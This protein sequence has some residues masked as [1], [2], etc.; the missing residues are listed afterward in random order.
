M[1]IIRSKVNQDFTIVLNS[2][3]DDKEFSSKYL[4]TFLRL[5]S[6][7]YGW[8]VSAD[9]LATLYPTEKRD[10]YRSALKHMC[11]LGYLIRIPQPRVNGRFSKAIMELYDKRQI[12]FS[13]TDEQVDRL[14][15][16]EELSEEEIKEIYPQ[17]INRHGSAVPMNPT[18][19]NIKSLRSKDRKNK[20]PPYPPKGESAGDFA[21]SFEEDSSE[22][23]EEYGP[24]GL[25]KLT[26]KQYETLLKLPW[27]HKVDEL[28]EELALYIGSSGKRYKSHFYTIQDWHARKQKEKK[29]KLKGS[30]RDGSS[31]K[32]ESESDTW[33]P[34]G[35]E[36]N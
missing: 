13:L 20:Q 4:G 19:E 27:G 6:K 16:I 28:I 11:K 3:T 5:I 9:G 31:L 29:E 30:K 24:D 34:E 2:V 12:E 36:E 8:E 18:K 25:V 32:F 1:S 23:K 35:W 26:M 15:A 7:G 17:R 33:T 10:F 14:F 21:D 22:E